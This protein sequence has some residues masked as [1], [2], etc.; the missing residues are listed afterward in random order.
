MRSALRQLATLAFGLVLLG[1]SG[2]TSS[3][4]AAS[5]S[6]SVPPVPSGSASVEELARQ[7]C[8]AAVVDECV[9]AV[10][11][12]ASAGLPAA[13]CIFPGD[14]WS[15]VTPQA[16]DIVGSS[17]GTDGTGKIQILIVK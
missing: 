2:T 12:A 14:K 17:C 1:C 7:A 5:L 11:G 16:G 6:V 4:P 3:S 9:T 10:V 13:L 8:P 15:V